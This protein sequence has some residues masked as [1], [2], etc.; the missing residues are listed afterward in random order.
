[1]HA[2]IVIAV[3][4]KHEDKFGRLLLVVKEATSFGHAFAIKSESSAEARRTCSVKTPLHFVG[5]NSP[6]S[7]NKVRLSR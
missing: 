4:V 6:T 2:R 5:A 7:E 1:M 3:K